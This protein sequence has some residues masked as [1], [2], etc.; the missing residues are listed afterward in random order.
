L[1]P[2][3]LDQ[4]NL[5]IQNGLELQENDSWH[6]SSE[7]NLFLVNRPGPLVKLPWMIFGPKIMAT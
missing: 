6:V 5:G 1:T 4:L 3:Y 2:N 7:E